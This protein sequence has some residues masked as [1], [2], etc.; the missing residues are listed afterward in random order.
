[1][2]MHPVLF[3]VLLA[4]GLNSSLGAAEVIRSRA[5]GPWSAASTWEPARVP[6]A[7]DR[8]LVRAGHR[9]EYDVESDEVVR[10]ITIGGKLEFSTTRAT[11]LNVGLI[12]I[13]PGDDYAEEGFACSAHVEAGKPG[14]ERPTLQVGPIPETFTARIRLHAVE[15]L[16]PQSC[17]AIVCCGGRMDFEGARLARSWVKLGATAQPGQ[18]GLVLAEPVTGW[19]VGDRIIVTAANL[20]DEDRDEPRTEERVIV[21]VD[22]ITLRLDRPLEHGHL[23]EGDFRGEVANLSRNVVVESADPSGVRGHTMYHAGSAGSVRW[24]EFRHLGK[25]G[26]LGRYSLHFHLAGDTM[27]GSVVEGASIWDSHNRWLVIHGTNRLVVRD[28]VGYQSVGH[29][30]YLE[31]GSEVYNVLDRNLG[32]QARRGRK[33]PDQALPFDGNEG[34][35]FWWANSLNSFT[36]NVAVEN[37]RYGFRFEATPGSTFKTEFDVLQPDGSEKRVDVRT[38][39]FVRFEDNESHSEAGLYAFNLGEGVRGI[40]PDERH[41]FVV[42]NCRAW[43]VHY[44]FRVQVPSLVMENIRIHRA[45]YGIYHPN[46]NRHAYRNLEISR[47]TAEPFNRGHDDD[48][49][50]AGVVTVDGLTFRDMKGY[51][52]PLIQ[53]TDTNDDGAAAL[54]IRGLKVENF[55]GGDHRS[56]VNRGGGPRPAP[57]SDTGVPVF[58]HDWYGPG[59]HAKVVSTAARDFG[60]DGLMYREEKPLTGDESRVAETTGVSFPTM[61]RPVDDLPPSTVVTDVIEGKGRHVRG[62]CID[63]GDVRRVVVN[64]KEAR[65]LAPNFAEWEITVSGGVE[66]IVAHAEDTAGNVEKLAQQW[67]P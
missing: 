45:V 38:L 50:Q 12:L 24:A 64:G 32:V 49:H 43:D 53:M 54:H 30:F 33:L 63:N 62:V 8:V 22:G 14:A 18:T 11:R 34:A 51:G 40:G 23:G 15:G 13:R 36:R 5:S 26:V 58:L 9:V 60:K 44:A 52:M 2:R 59:R 29:G 67:T 3:L 48:S 10:G 7:G 27:R 25:K 4:L 56:I 19:R 47:T 1:M 57:E 31:D 42:R 65:S 39:P 55:T 41:P 37:D 61:L 17:P 20:K 46:F 28:C 21:A 6:G 16:D 66:P 35:A